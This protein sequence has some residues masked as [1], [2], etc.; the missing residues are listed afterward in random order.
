MYATEALFCG[1]PSSPMKYDEVVELV[2][3][4]WLWTANNVEG[5]GLA[6][7]RHGS[8]VG[9]ARWTNGNEPPRRSTKT[10]HARRTS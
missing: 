2:V 10:L 5:N 9:R 6:L 4:L 3:F 8:G 1:G 7:A